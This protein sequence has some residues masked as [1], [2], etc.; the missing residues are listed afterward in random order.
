LIEIDENTGL[1][2]FI[3]LKL[4]LQNLLKRKVDLVEYSIIRA[5]IKEQILKEEVSIL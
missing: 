3:K 1:I 5:E 4:S 2:D